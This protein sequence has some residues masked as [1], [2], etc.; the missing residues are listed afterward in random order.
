M[1]KILILALAFSALTAAAEGKKAKKD[2]KTPTYEF[3]DVKIN[4]QTPVKDQASS[5]TCWS[6]SGMGFIEAELLRQG[7]GTFDLADMWVVRHT[8][9]E[10]AVKY[11]RMHGTVNLAAGGASH[12]VFN[13]I[14]KYG[15]VPEEVYTGLNYGT[16][17]HRHG[18]LDNVI[19]AYM[20]AVLKN[21]NRS[22][23]C[24]WQTGLN[25][26]LDAYLGEMPAEF[27]YEGKTY[28]PKSFAQFL[29]IKADDYI[30][31]T[32]FSHHPYGASFAIEVPDNWAAD[33]SL[34]LPLDQFMDVIDN[35]LEN[36]MSVFWASDVSEK[37][38]KYNKGYAVLPEMKL[39]NLSD[40]EK[41]KWSE[42]TTEELTKTIN[43]ADEIVTEMTITP[44]LRQKWYDNWET[45]DDHGMVIVGTAKDQNGKTFYKVKNSWNTTNPFG[46][47]FYASRAFVEGKTLN[48]IVPKSALK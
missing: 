25:G 31:I 38:F 36:N 12:D 16:D 34:N 45:T 7:K 39:E 17:E 35:A 27:E 44:E 28:T 6:F 14:D 30:S 29:E 3:T 26:I 9:F 5:G 22:L 19:K 37:G 32:S 47:Y 46:G 48:V 2:K 8:Y 21:A 18:E 4:P 43:A 33:V 20:D 24:A 1:K 23:T 11:A 13:M 10:K 15:I 42:L 41:A 40:S